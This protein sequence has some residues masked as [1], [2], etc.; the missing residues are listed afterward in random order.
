MCDG[1]REVGARGN[2]KPR[3][4][5]AGEM[6]PHPLGH[7]RRA[8]WRERW[9]KGSERTCMWPQGGHSLPGAREDGKGAGDSASTGV[10]ALGRLTADGAHAGASRVRAPD[11]LGGSGTS[12]S[13]PSRAR[14]AWTLFSGSGAA[15]G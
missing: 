8:V 9:D 5:A 4:V 15:E 10:T 11:G 1:C 13:T 12:A 3:A 6:R 14:G 7:W 2:L